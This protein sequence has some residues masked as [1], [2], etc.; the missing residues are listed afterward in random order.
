MVCFAYPAALANQKP[1]NPIDNFFSSKCSLLD[2]C[3][4]VSYDRNIMIFLQIWGVSEYAFIS[5]IWS[6]LNGK[7][8]I[9]IQ[10]PKNR[11]PTF[12]PGHD[13]VVYKLW[14]VQEEQIEMLRFQLREKAELLDKSGTNSQTRHR[15]EHGL[16]AWPSS[17][18]QTPPFSKS[19]W[20]LGVFLF[21]GFRFC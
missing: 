5:R 10:G 17:L 15:T 13:I 3:D 14:H 9:R 4:K 19:A 20:V 7:K 16:L 18:A 8:L 21:L 1:G 2:I 12:N 6:I 11:I